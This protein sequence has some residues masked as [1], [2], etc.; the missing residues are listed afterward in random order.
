MINL[1][2][3]SFEKKLNEWKWDK[4]IVTVE[5]VLVNCALSGMMR[6]VQSYY[7]GIVKGKWNYGKAILFNNLFLSK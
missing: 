5:I 6:M 7:L 4:V 3:W 1:F 2:S